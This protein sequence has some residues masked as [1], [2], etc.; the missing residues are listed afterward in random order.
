MSDK[1]QFVVESHRDLDTIELES[2]ASRRQAKAYRTSGNLRK[3]RLKDIIHPR[4]VSA[5][6][7]ELHSKRECATTTPLGFDISLSDLT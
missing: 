4:I 6:F 5:W 2:P 3:N 7:Q 1:L